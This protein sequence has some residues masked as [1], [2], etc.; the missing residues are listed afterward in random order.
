MGSQSE[1]PSAALDSTGSLSWLWR[2]QRRSYR[3]CPPAPAQHVQSGPSLLKLRI[4]LYS[5]KSSPSKKKFQ[6]TLKCLGCTI[7]VLTTLS[8]SFNLSHIS[9]LTVVLKQFEA[10]LSFTEYLTD[11]NNFQLNVTKHYCIKLQNLCIT[12]CNAR[13]KDGVGRATCWGMQ[14]RC[15]AIDLPE[16]TPFR[17]CSHPHSLTRQ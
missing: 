2:L 3:I 10:C 4:R 16:P 1:A 6:P 11:Q 17:N 12:L 9:Q 5:V 8:L 7:V 13:L 14:T 15:P